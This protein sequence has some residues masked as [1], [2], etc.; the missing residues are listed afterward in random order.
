LVA[1]ASTAMGDHKVGM[2]ITTATA[3]CLGR[4]LL[5]CG[6]AQEDLPL[7]HLTTGQ[8]DRHLLW[9]GG[10]RLEEALADPL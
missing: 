9:G 2:V 8:A 5:K 7:R 4:H 3:G 6:V 1:M 10:H